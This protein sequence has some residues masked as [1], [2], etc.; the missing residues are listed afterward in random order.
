MAG[1]S[2]RVSG[3]DLLTN[4]LVYIPLGFLL[5]LN[6]PTKAGFAAK[7]LIS[8][9]L[10]TILS[11]TMEY[12]QMFLPSR[13][14]SLSDVLLN[15][16]SCCC[17]ALCIWGQDKRSPIGKR[18]RVLRH[19]WFNDGR[20]TDTGLI[21]LGVWVLVQ[22]APFVPSLD[23][24]DIKN[25]LKPIW[26]AVH[27]LSRFD[28]YKAATYSF[29]IAALAAAWIQVLRFSRTAYLWHFIFVGSVLF[30]KILIAGRQL[31]LE[32]LVGLCVG[33]S[34]LFLLQLVPKDRIP[35]V[36]I[37]L[38][39]AGFTVDEL[40]PVVSE[41]ANFHSFNWI[42]F[43]SQIEN[44]VTGIGSILEGGWPFAAMAYFF[45]TAGIFRRKILTFLV[46]GV[47]LAAIVFLLEMAQKQ[48]PGRYPDSTTVLLAVVGW[49]LPWLFLAGNMGGK[50][51]IEKKT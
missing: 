10:G 28:V 44:E 27:D 4:I 9:V 12:L 11:I 15:S 30:C 22:L 31:S 50:M 3:S 36:A 41:A 37:G 26:Y 17:G 14:S 38:V 40:R 33:T 7:V 16:F 20:I 8:V 34:A 21:I 1:W 49:S 46:G 45:V 47:S 25:G 23:V 48:I 19:R 18:L 29:Y 43:S 6:V 2:G 39:M 13:T 32:A 51:R 42:P 24:G 5:A 35:L